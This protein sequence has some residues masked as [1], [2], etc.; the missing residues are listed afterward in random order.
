ML[1]LSRRRG[2]SVVIGNGIQVSVASISRSRVRIAIEAPRE[3]AVDRGE[4]WLRKQALVEGSG[5]ADSVIPLTGDV[6]LA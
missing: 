3:V 6:P 1:V 5:T 2:E 4:I